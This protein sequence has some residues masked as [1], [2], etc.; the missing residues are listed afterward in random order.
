MRHPACVKTGPPKGGP[1]P[2]TRSLRGLDALSFLMADVRDGIGPFLAIFLTG[3]LHWSSRDIGLVMGVSGLA[4]ALSQVPAGMLVDATRAKRALIAVSAGIVA[5]GCLLIARCPTLPV[6]LVTQTALALV[7]AVMGPSLAALSLGVVG[8]HLLPARVS[9]NE[10]FNHAGNVCAAVLAGTLGQYAG[11]AWLFYLVCLF[12]V[13]SV[14]AVMRVRPSDID[15]ERSRGGETLRTAD[16]VGRPIPLRTLLR[17]RELMAFLVTVVL[18][19]GGNAAMLPLAAQMLAK[20]APGSDVIGLGACV[21]A[22]QCVMMVVAASVGRALR[23]CVGRRT[24]FLM[25]LAILPLRGLLFALTDN[26]W[27]VVGIQLL[28]GVSAGI[29]GVIATVIAADLMRGTGRFNLAQGATSLAVGIGAGLSNLASGLVVDRFGFSAAFGMLAAI[30]AI[31]LAVFALFMPET[32]PADEST[33][34]S[35]E[36]HASRTP[37]PITGVAE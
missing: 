1:V 13:A 37:H 24:I 30:A 26:T 20:H 15:H 27:L 18:F 10:T 9:R 19:H 17:R 33:S 14:I 23:A 6:I 35:D 4:A 36:N 31:A 2:S 5:M 21:I 28:D 32:R 8:H 12:A 25:A 34:A 11:T 16:G 29:F 3:T 7:A 22:A